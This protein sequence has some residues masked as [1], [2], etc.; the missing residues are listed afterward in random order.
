[1]TARYADHILGPDTHANLP[2]AADVPDHAQYRCTTHD[3]TYLND[4]GTWVDYQANAAAVPVGGT[5]GQVLAKNSGADYDT[6]WATPSGGGSAYP[7]GSADQPPT[8]PNAKDDEFDGTSSVTWSNTPTPPTS[9]DINTTRPGHAYLKPPAGTTYSGKVQAVPGAYP[10]TITAKFI[11]TGRAANNRRGGIILAPAVPTG[12]SNIWY[13]GGNYSSGLGGAITGRLKATY[14]GTYISDPGV[15]PFDGWWGPYYVK[16]KVNSATS[17][18][19]WISL[20]GYAWVP[21]E[22]GAN[23][24]FTPDTMGIAATSDGATPELFCDFF[25]II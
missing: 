17:I 23:P 7:L 14:A 8:S 4:A 11:S 22:A 25:R 12:T 15:F 9:W 20:D 19:S 24:G 21:V 2:A 16:V 10:F 5:T 3:K 18:D 6:G 1:M 13:V